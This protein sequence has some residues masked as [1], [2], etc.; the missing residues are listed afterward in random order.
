[1]D[2]EFIKKYSVEIPKLEFGENREAFEIDSSFF[3]AFEHAPIADGDVNVEANFYRHKRHLEARLL[4]QGEITLRCDRCLEP[5]PYPIDFK[6]LVIYSYDEDLDFGT[7][8]VVVIDEDN[9]ILDLS[10][11]LFDFVSLQVPLRRVPAPEIHT[12]PDHVLELL[13]LKESKTKQVATIDE[14]DIDPRWA[15]L[16]KLKD[17]L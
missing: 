5:Y 1:M 4:F 7:D 17:K 15:A 10:R 14:D 6:T 13:G 2:K 3:D 12:C 8:E 9:P 11:D 16:K